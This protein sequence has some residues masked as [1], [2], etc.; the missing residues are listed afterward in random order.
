MDGLGRAI[1]AGSAVALNGKTY[2]IEPL[3]LRDI[4]RIENRIVATRVYPIDTLLEMANK[5][6]DPK[7]VEGQIELAVKELRKDRTARIVT[8]E[9]FDKWLVTGEGIVF[10]GW[11]CLRKNHSQFDT[12][13]DALGLFAKASSEEITAFV[14]HRDVISG[15]HLL[16]VLDWPENGRRGKR[17]DD[18]FENRKY[19]P[20]PW[21]AM[22]RK[23]AEARFFSKHDI[24]DWTLYEYN[25]Q[26]MDEND[27]GGVRRMSAEDAEGVSRKKIVHIGPGGKG[28]DEWRRYQQVADQRRKQQQQTE[29]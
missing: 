9:E 26:T 15:I 21:R 5:L 24:E 20:I 27:L 28:L 19:R 1:G 6:S 23:L 11:L 7:V 25:V 17:A 10:S 13:E 29:E 12:L 2:L 4:G 16:A 14:R 22:I 18:P 8:V 3:T